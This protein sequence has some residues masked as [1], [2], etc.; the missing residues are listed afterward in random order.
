MNASDGT[1]GGPLRNLARLRDVGSRRASSYDRTGG[2]EDFVWIE[3]GE[4]HQL[5]DVNGPGCIT[6][7]WMTSASKEAH[8]LRKLVLRMWWD[9]EEAPSVEVPLG[10]FF[11]LGHAQTRNFASLPLAMAPQ[12][13]RGFTCYF[14]MPFASHARVAVESQCTQE[15]ARLY[16][17]VDYETYARLAP[18]LG[19]FHAQWR[20]QNPTDGISPDGM[21]FVDY[22]FGGT[23]P[24]GEGNYVILEAEGRGHYV[25]CHLDIENLTET[26]GRNWYGEG[27]DMIFVDGEPFPPSLHGTGT[28]DYFNTAWCPQEA[29]SSP[30]FGITMPGGPNWS[31]K[32]SLYRYHV[33]DP[34]HFRTSIRVTIEHGHANRRA[35]DYA[36]T[37]YWYQAEPHKTFPPLS[38]VAMRLPRSD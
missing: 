17:Y 19:R 30:Y 7:I 28:E 4:M 38:A 22:Q 25:G 11:G 35:D 29:Y 5:L 26:R 23:N 37:A 6:H 3:P 13:G 34:I 2:N 10:D 8:Y 24:S 14:P 9:E 21:D 36:S 33:E 16:Y 27:D 15:P 20:R 32:I 31:G 18:D 12:G 1:L